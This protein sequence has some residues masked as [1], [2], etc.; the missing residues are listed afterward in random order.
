MKS[1]LVIDVWG[2][3]SGEVKLDNVNISTR[4][5]M[6]QDKLSNGHSKQNNAGDD[7]ERYKLLCEINTYKRRAERM[8]KKMVSTLLKNKSRLLNTISNLMLAC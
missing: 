1:P 3:Q 5:L 2:K 8:N 4:Q 7:D 6:N